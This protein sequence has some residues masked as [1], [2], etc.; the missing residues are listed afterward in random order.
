M[1]MRASKSG[2]SSEKACRGKHQ[3]RDMTSVLRDRHQAR[4]KV[5]REHNLVNAL[6]TGTVGPPVP[7]STPQRLPFSYRLEPRGVS[8]AW[9]RISAARIARGYCGA[10]CLVLQHVGGGKQ[11]SVLD[12]PHARVHGSILFVFRCR[13]VGV[14]HRH[15]QT[16]SQVAGET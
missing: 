12:A 16:Y 10:Q 1:E 8:L 15:N 9:R 5:P 2:Q 6:F 3:S 14:Q 13:I 7:A 4:E 11:S